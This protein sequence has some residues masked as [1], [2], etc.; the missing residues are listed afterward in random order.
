MEAEDFPLPTKPDDF[1]Q[2]HLSIS[3]DGKMSL[4]VT[5]RGQVT[6]RRTTS[7]QDELLYWVFADKAFA[8]GWTYSK[9]NRVE[10]EDFRRAAFSHALEEMK[11]LSN[12]WFK[13]FQ[14]EIEEILKANPYNDN[15]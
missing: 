2:E 3:D 12:D 9:E 10:G 6:K 13:R 1:G 11:K 15:R 5:E 14:V 7:S 8:R 4:I